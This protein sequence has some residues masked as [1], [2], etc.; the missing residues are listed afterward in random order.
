ME[1]KFTDPELGDIILRRSLKARNYTIKIANGAISAIM[2]MR[3]DE[4]K[5][6]DF[7]NQRRERLKKALIKHPTREILSEQTEMQ[8]LT[9]DVRIRRAPKQ[10]K[11]HMFLKEKQLTIACPEDTDFENAEVQKLLRRLLQAAMRHEAKRILPPKVKQLASQ[12][13][14]SYTGVTIKNN[15]SNWG[16]CS[17]RKHINLSLSLMQLPEHLIDYVILHE[18]C[19]TVEMNH[20]D[21][22]WHLMDHVTGNRAKALR[23]ELKQYHPIY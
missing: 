19:H 17:A 13:G 23:T 14:F 8:T 4:Q 16:S 21:R 11:F 15:K 10:D 1:K 5:M 9:F 22:F 20:S 12:Y 2:P 3:G 6:I 7:I 18:L